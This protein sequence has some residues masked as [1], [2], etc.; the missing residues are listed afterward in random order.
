M[1][2]RVVER[3]PATEHIDAA[4][5]LA[6]HVISRGAIVSRIP[7]VRGVNVHWVGFLQAE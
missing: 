5:L 7:T 4:D 3:E 2:G 1:P 6:D